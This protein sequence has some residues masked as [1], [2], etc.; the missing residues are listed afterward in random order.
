MM[1]NVLEFEVAEKPRFISSGA[2][3]TDAAA[4]SILGS[5]SNGWRNFSVDF[6]TFLQQ[7]G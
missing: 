7:S 5:R 1:V 2:V 6:S 4:M 3:T